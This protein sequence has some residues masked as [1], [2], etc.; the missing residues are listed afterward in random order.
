VYD[1]K[2]VAART[3]EAYEVAIA[4]HKS[5]RETSTYRK[6]PEEAIADFST[7]IYSYQRNLY[8]FMYLNSISF[9]IQHWQTLA[10]NQP[11]LFKDKVALGFGSILA[12]ILR[13]PW[14]L[15]NYLDKSR[16]KI[17][18]TEE[19]MQRSVKKELLHL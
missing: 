13:Q 3:V 10:K 7:F 4:L 14:P 8:E 18:A 1:K 6:N 15:R 19:E 11:Q 2:E 9:R 12:K 17:T 5:K 16:Q